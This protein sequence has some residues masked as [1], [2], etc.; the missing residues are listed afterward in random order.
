MDY[1]RLIG[2]AWN[3]TW[4][5]RF[6]WIL[7]LFAPAGVGGCGLNFNVPSNFN[8]PSPGRTQ[9][10]PANSLPFPTGGPNGVNQFERIGPIV[11][12]WIAAHLGLILAVAA[13]ALILFLL[14]LF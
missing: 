6:L 2:D 4:R 1:G 8:T 7:A 5:Y 10:G 12:A 13:I 3:M 14:F 11:A 9:P